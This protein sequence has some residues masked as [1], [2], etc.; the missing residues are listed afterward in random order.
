MATFFL[1]EIKVKTV[2]EIMFDLLLI[3]KNNI[4]NKKITYLTK[5]LLTKYG[6]VYFTGPQLKPTGYFLVEQLLTT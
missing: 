1:P 2:L 5:I 3:F 6:R 4:V